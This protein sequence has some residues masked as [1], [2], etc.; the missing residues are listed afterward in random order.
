MQPQ[1]IHNTEISLVE[2]PRRDEKPLVKSAL[3]AY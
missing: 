2:N 1:G 3:L